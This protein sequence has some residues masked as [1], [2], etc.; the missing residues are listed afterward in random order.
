M[1]APLAARMRPRNVAE[2]LGQEHIL[3]PGKPL[4]KGIE[5][6]VLHSM[7]FWGPPGTG[8]TTLAELIASAA[9]ARVAR[10]SAVTSGVKDIRKAVEEAKLHQQQGVRTLVF[11]DE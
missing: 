1:P 4:R 8:K 7:I 6:G 9:D 10:L 11:V 2:Y 3:A 5:Q